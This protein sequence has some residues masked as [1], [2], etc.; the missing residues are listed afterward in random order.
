MS[1]SAPQV[2]FAKTCWFSEI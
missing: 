2:L 1:Y